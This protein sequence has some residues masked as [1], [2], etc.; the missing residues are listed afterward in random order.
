MNTQAASKADVAATEHRLG[1]KIDEV[2]HRL[3]KR[4]DEVEH[5]RDGHTGGGGR[6]EFAD[7]RAAVRNDACKRRLDAGEGKLRPRQAESTPAP[8]KATVLQ[9]K[10]REAREAREPSIARPLRDLG[11]EGRLFRHI[12]HIGLD[13]VAVKRGAGL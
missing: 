9:R 13:P 8:T 11:R 5:R 3:G 2:D 10:P 6:D 4:I 12:A 7:L 1:A